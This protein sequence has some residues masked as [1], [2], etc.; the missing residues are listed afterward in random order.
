MLLTGRCEEELEDTE[1][2]VEAADPAPVAVEGADDDDA[3]AVG[4]EDIVV[5]LG[6]LEDPVGEPPPGDRSHVGT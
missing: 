1:E 5:G 2:E 4:C 6:M 3:D